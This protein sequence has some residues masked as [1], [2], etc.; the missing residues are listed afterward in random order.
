MDL[1]GVV[2]LA[3]HHIHALVTDITRDQ[4]KHKG[5]IMIIYILD[6]TSRLKKGG[7]VYKRLFLGL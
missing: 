4:G 3:R 7:V 5:Y 2:V 6:G 1:W